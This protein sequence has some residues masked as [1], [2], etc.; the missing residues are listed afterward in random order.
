M[1]KSVWATVYKGL[2]STVA[3]VRVHETEREKQSTCEAVC[4]KQG[5]WDSI[6][7]S[8]RAS[9]QES[10]R[11]YLFEYEWRERLFVC[12]MSWVWG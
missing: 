8:V 11:E 1:G 4:M 9:V 5:M 2:T 3:Y 6:Y 7:E 10:V 12:G